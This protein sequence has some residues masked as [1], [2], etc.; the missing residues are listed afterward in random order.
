ME[1]AFVVD[2]LTVSVEFP[3]SSMSNKSE[4][5]TSTVEFPS[6]SSLELLCIVGIPRAEKAES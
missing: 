1:V 4:F 3:D 2:P 6:I 5:S